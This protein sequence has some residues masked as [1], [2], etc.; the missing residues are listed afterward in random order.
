MCARAATGA[1]LLHS[2][3][4]LQHPAL[5]FSNG[6]HMILVGLGQAGQMRQAVRQAC[7]R[8]CRGSLPQEGCICQSSLDNAE[9]ALHTCAACRTPC[10]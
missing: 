1:R 4:M 8:P 5:T 7:Q 10:F 3:R 6:A 9:Y 2:M